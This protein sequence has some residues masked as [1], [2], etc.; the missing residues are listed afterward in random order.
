MVELCGSIGFVPVVARGRFVGDRVQLGGRGTSAGVCRVRTAGKKF[1][2]VAVAK[3]ERKS[4]WRRVQVAAF[5]VLVG[6]GV[7]LSSRPA[8]SL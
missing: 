3:N 1:A 4:L 5:S 2:V 8:V 6:C 7:A